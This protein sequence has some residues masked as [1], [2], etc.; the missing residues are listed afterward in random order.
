MRSQWADAKSEVAATA[1]EMADLG[2]V[3]GSSGNV[4]LR[5]PSSGGAGELFAVTPRGKPYRKLGDE[6]IVVVDSDIEPIEGDLSPSSETL[7][8][9]GI[10][11]A[12]PDVQA[13]I[14][15]HSV[16]SS[17]A[18]VAGLEIPAIIDE[19][20]VT[21]GGAVRTS[22]YA[23]PGTEELADNVCAALGERAA[24]LIRNHGAVGVARDLS[25]ALDVCALVERVAQIFIYA[26]LL[27]KVSPLP[28]DIIET[29]TALY[30]MGQQALAGN[31]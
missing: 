30:R 4:S 11:R 5:I 6:D 25:G 27:G 24:A 13:V 16:F 22:E 3:T 15:T 12:R 29:E 23:F 8:H 19:M 31:S 7:L 2:L 1:R 14:H 20:V 18:A 21:I 10:Y 26:S 28:E 9:V 17:V